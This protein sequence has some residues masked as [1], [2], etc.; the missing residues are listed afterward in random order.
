MK[1]G[2]VKTND[3]AYICLPEVD[4]EK[5]WSNGKQSDAWRRA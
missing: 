3:G 4:R 5:E 2:F 1:Q